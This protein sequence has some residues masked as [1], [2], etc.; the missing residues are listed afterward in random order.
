MIELRWLERV[1]KA[2]GLGYERMAIR[3][4][5]QFRQMSNIEEIGIQ[6]PIWAE[7][8]DVPIEVIGDCKKEE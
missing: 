8:Q 6:P 7:W 4:V 1:E 2:E 5:L 3:T